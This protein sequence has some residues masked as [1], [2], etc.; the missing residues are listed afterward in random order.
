MQK[1]LKTRDR[2]ICHLGFTLIAVVTANQSKGHEP[3]GRPKDPRI[4]N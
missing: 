1:N 2:E 3:G 4:A